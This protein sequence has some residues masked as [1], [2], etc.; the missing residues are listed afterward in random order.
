MFLGA[1]KAPSVL[2]IH[3]QPFQDNES[4]VVDIAIFVASLLGFFIVYINQSTH[5]RGLLQSSVLP[6]FLSMHFLL[7]FIWLWVIRV[8]RGNLFLSLASSLTLINRICHRSLMQTEDSQ[9]MVK[10]IMPKTRFTEFP[11]LSVDPKVGISRSSSDTN[12]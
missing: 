10:R 12:V 11:A 6:V 2:K 3:C 7:F 8:G 5:H 1:V 9:P 4:V